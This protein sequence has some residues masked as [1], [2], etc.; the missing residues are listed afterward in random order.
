MWNW[1][2]GFNF[3]K[4]T[5]VWTFIM[6]NIVYNGF[7]GYIAWLIIGRQLFDNNLNWML[8]FIGYPALLIGFI[9]GILHVFK[10]E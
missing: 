8:C 4:K 9:S 6:L 3:K 7:L 2:S 5:R 1:L 10:Y